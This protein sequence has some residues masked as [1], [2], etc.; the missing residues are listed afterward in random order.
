MAGG[1]AFF[2]DPS[3]QTADKETSENTR[4]RVNGFTGMLI[5]APGGFESF[6][7]AR[8]RGKRAE[9]VAVGVKQG[10][11]LIVSHCTPSTFPR[12]EATPRGVSRVPEQPASRPSGPLGGES[13]QSPPRMSNFKPWSWSACPRYATGKDRRNR[14]GRAETGF[15]KHFTPLLALLLSAAAAR[16]DDWPQLQG[17]ALRSGNAPTAA[18]KT[19]LGLVG[20]V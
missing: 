19:P 17:N 4:E 2:G 9:G 8:R 1:S 3:P 13:L 6:L 10:P 18:V 12:G 14:L 16:G 7:D 11:A 5:R 20:A 15:M